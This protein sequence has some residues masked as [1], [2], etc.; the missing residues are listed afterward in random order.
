[1]DHSEIIA[2]F[3]TTKKCCIT[4]SF[5]C[6]HNETIACGLDEDTRLDQRYCLQCISGIFHTSLDKTKRE[7]AEKR[8][9]VSEG[10]QFLATGFAD[11]ASYQYEYVNTAETFFMRQE[12]SSEEIIHATGLKWLATRGS[13]KILGEKSQ[14]PLCKKGE[15]FSGLVQTQLKQ[16]TLDDYLTKKT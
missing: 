3:A 4:Y 5:H 7:R 2:S 11:G 6:P 1:M 10:H 16:K 14:T 12:P 8:N 13:Y 9:K 15:E